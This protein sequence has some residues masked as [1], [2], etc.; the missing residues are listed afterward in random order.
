MVFV[1]RR[2][3]QL[4][5]LPDGGSDTEAVGLDSLRSVPAWVLLGEPGAGKSEAF[6]SEAQSDTGLRLTIAEFVYS[7]IDEAWK[8]KCLFLDGLDEV[9]ASATTVSILVQVK[10]KLRKLGLPNFRIACR[11]ADWR[12]Q[13]DLEEIIGA[14][15]NGQLPIYTLEPLTH[16]DIK[17]ILEDNF[18]R[19]D[20]ENF[21]AQ[22]GAPGI[23]ALLSNPQPLGLTVKALGGK[24][25]PSSRDETYRLACEA[26]F[27]TTDWQ[28]ASAVVLIGAASSSPAET[29]APAAATLGTICWSCFRLAPSG[30]P[31]PAPPAAAGNASCAPADANCRW[32][33]SMQAL[34][35][36]RKKS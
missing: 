13:S 24:T 30:L 18:N 35:E 5:Q 23:N 33:A 27:G 32:L 25:W 10:S 20:A 3:K 11:A 7:D 29:R 8:D 14:S 6:K 2:V 15:P 28:M 16:A 22:A 31:A 12:G 19:S 34:I 36:I 9:R 26:G 17:R 21:I 1:Y 4:S